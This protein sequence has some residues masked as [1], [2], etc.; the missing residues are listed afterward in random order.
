[1]PDASR[2]ITGDHDPNG[3]LLMTFSASPDSLRANPSAKPP[4]TIHITLQLISSRSRALITPVNAN[5][6]IG[7]M[8]T[9]LE[10]TP[11][12]R[13][14]IQSNTVTMN[15]P[16]TTMV[17]QLCCTSPSISSCMVFFLNGKKVLSR[18]QPISNSTTVSGS[19]YIIHSPNPMPRLRPVGELRYF[20][21]MALGRCFQERDMNARIYCREGQDCLWWYLRSRIRI[22]QYGKCSMDFRVWCSLLMKM[23]WI[24]AET[25]LQD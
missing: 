10:P 20:S 9:V 7:I 5:T 11:V 14:Q 4:A 17:R 16:A 6:T 15:V 18:N 25:D 1:M 23:Q 2:I 22:F 8:A 19:I 21:A 3:M 13:S 24:S 12:Q